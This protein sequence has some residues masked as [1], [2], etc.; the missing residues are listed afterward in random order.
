MS[1]RS[2]HDQSDPLDRDYDHF[3]HPWYYRMIEMESLRVSGIDAPRLSTVDEQTETIARATK[4]ADMAT[5]PY[6][7][8]TCACRL[9]N[10]NRAI[11]S[12]S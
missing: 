12:K 3:Q 1:N 5:R 8:K 10:R 9:N 7:L 4:N 2:R 6:G 11:R